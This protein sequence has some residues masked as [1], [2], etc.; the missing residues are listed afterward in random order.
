MTADAH[1][2]DAALGREGRTREVRDRAVPEVGIQRY[3]LVGVVE[4][5]RPPHNHLGDGVVGELAAAFEGLDADPDCRA[6]VLCAEGRSFCA[7]ADFSGR[8]PEAAS[9]TE[10]RGTVT[11]SMD[12]ERMSRR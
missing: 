9:H 5:R 6:I 10:V 3:G 8:R 1:L 2:A 4:M 12:D 11:A 7:G